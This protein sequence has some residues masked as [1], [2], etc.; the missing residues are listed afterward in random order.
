MAKERGKKIDRR[1]YTI[2]TTYFVHKK[3]QAFHAL[4]TYRQIAKQSERFLDLYNM[5]DVLKLTKNKI[6]FLV[7]ILINRNIKN[8]I[9]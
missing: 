5:L 3:N 6:T 2:K 9:I 8:I 4:H 7:P 1:D